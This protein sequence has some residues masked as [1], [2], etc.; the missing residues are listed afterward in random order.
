MTLCIAAICDDVENKSAKIVLCADQQREEQGVGGSETEDK[1][2]FVKKAWPALIAGILSRADELLDVYTASLKDVQGLSEY[3]LLEYLR[4]PLHIQKRNLVNDY[5][6]Q[7]YAFD[8]DYFYSEGA[9]T[10]PEAIVTK[11]SDEITRIKVEAQ[12]IIAG[13]ID[14]TN[15]TSGNV[16]LEP[17]LGVV[18]EQST[19]S[20]TKDDIRIESSFAAIGSGSLPALASLYRR[21]QSSTDSLAQTIYNVYEANR[22]SEEVPGVGKDYV[23]IYVLRQDGRLDALTEAGYTHLRKMYKQFGPKDI[24]DEKVLTMEANCFEPN[25]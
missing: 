9:K 14:R 3:T 19:H 15:L 10:F 22:L 5:L 7:T 2:G 1:L 8:A 20:S 12:L 11:I 18:E 21:Q 25:S 23:D 17:F 6:Q 4:N 24:P 13:F 16:T